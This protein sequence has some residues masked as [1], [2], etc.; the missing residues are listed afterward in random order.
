MDAY[1]GDIKRSTRRET[2]LTE[3]LVSEPVT[4]QADR[5][6]HAL[7]FLGHAEILRTN[8]LIFGEKLDVPLGRGILIQDARMMCCHWSGVKRSVCLFLI[9]IGPAG[10]LIALL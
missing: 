7:C 2:F 4:K 10:S 5:I 6:L 1:L 3:E 8:D 9:P